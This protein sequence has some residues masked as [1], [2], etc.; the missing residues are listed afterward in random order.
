MKKKAE[1][2]TASQVDNL[3]DFQRLVYC[4]SHK[5]AVKTKG[6]DFFVQVRIDPAIRAFLEV[7]KEK[8]GISHGKTVAHILREK[9]PYLLQD[10][11]AFGGDLGKDAQKAYEVK[12]KQLVK[13]AM[14]EKKA[15]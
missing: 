15:C 5:G 4:V 2:L 1:N 11:E 13:E 3:G 8:T 6:E 10:F 14:K 7:V 9:L 12:V